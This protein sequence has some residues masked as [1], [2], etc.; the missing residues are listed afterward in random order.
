[1][2][3]LR[4]TLCSLFVFALPLVVGVAAHAAVSRTYVAMSG[5]DAN[6][7]ATPS[8]PCLTF[9]GA[10]G[11]TSAGGE[12]IA[13]ES[14][15]YGKLAINRAISIIGAPGVHAE[16]TST[17][18]NNAVTI[19][20]PLSA[21]VILRNLHLAG[22]NANKGVYLISG[23]SLIVENCTITGFTN[24]IYVKNSSTATF[25]LRNTNVDNSNEGVVL[26]P[27]GT[28]FNK[29]IAAFVDNCRFRNYFKGFV[30]AGKYS[31]VTIRDSVF[32]GR[33]KDPAVTYGG[34]VASPNSAG[35]TRIMA[36]NN[37]VS[38][39]YLAIGTTTDGVA[40]ISIS[41]NV[42][43]HN[44][45]GVFVCCLSKMITMGNNRFEDNNDDGS[46]NLSSPLK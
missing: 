16:I 14:G 23:K 20:A 15:T 5:S 44:Q 2:N 6:S 12:V 22:P 7:C 8:D 11:K 41:Q 17:G 35:T 34:I 29:P 31:M 1:M 43:Y 24:G 39:N 4:L 45:L 27:T 3:K 25:Y 40:F 37:L 30:A 46:F 9:Q 32:E 19:Q 28:D 33:S 36:E 10:H 42:I 38:N 21:T 26:E 13:I 18:A